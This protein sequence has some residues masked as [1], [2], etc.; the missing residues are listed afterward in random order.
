M[1]HLFLFIAIA[2]VPH[3]EEDVLVKVSLAVIVGSVKHIA[4]AVRKQRVAGTQ[5]AFS[6]PHFTHRG[7][8]VYRMMPSKFTL[9]L[10]PSDRLLWRA[11]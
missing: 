10:P 2:E 5:R 9:N 7:T 8:L 4:I 6:F 1:I 11:L 3:G